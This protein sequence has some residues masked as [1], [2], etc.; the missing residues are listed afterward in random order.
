[1]GTGILRLR[2]EEIR[3]RYSLAPAIR[4]ASDSSSYSSA[5]RFHR[6]H[7]FQFLTKMD[8][9]SVAEPGGTFLLNSPYGPE[10]IWSKLPAEVQ[11]QIIDK[12]LKFFVVDGLK[13]AQEAGL[14]GRINTVLQTC[15]FALSKILPADEAIEH[16]KTAIRKTYG[17]RGETVLQRNFAAVDGTCGPAQFAFPRRSGHGHLLPPVPEHVLIL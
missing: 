13:V 5:G 14:A 17:K 9:L 1:M 16:I 10:E 12:R 15:F 3:R 4:T 6:L 11:Q 2:L 7:Q 8:V